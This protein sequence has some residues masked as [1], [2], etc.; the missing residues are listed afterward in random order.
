MWMQLS[1]QRPQTR[2]GQARLQQHRPL[3]ALAEPAIEVNRVR[4]ADE[5]AVGE[6]IEQELIATYRPYLNTQPRWSAP[7]ST[8]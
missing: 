6:Q 1:M 7:V 3:L 8:E 2:A 5:R 4:A